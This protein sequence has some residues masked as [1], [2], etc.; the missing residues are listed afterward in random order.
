MPFNS[1]QFMKRLVII[2]LVANLLTL[3]VFTTSCTSTASQMADSL[4]VYDQYYRTTE[5]LLSEIDKTYD[6]S[7]EWADSGKEENIDYYWIRYDI[8]Y[9][10]GLSISQTLNHL[11]RYHNETQRLLLMLEEQY[12]WSDTVGE[13]DLYCEW[14][15]INKQLN[16]DQ[17]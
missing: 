15:N 16:K 7:T 10:K 6:W 2:G 1:N 17:L 5:K 4:V 11:R 14:Y 3:C 9:T 13:S 8:N 12:G